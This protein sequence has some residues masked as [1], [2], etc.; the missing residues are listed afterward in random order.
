M[1]L[2]MCLLIPLLGTSLGSSM[3]FL[4]KNKLNDKFEKMLLGFASGVMMS[5]SVP[6]RMYRVADLFSTD[7][8]TIRIS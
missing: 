2:I 7:R 6:S 1:Q 3:V 5:A 4:M 8:S